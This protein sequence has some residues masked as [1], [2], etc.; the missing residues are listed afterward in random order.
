M[1]N[2]A[3]VDDDFILCS[4]LA[5]SDDTLSVQLL[6]RGSKSSCIDCAEVI[7]ALSYSGPKLVVESCVRW[8]PWT[9]YQD[10]LQKVEPH[11]VS[12]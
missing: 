6:H 8:M 3:E 2:Q 9:V 1:Q 4:V 5:F 10:A 7:S 11:E 12:T